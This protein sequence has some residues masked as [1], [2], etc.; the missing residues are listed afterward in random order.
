MW[1]GCF[2]GCRGIALAAISA[3]GGL[4]GPQT[5]AF[6]TCVKNLAQ[7]GASIRTRLRLV[8]KL[9]YPADPRD[10]KILA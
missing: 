2:R 5:P 9:D 6:G 8:Q 7:Q 10:G 3:V 4:A 1:H